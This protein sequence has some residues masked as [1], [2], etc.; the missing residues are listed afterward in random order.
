[1]TARP[2]SPV[3]K[4]LPLVF[5]FSKEPYL[6]VVSMGISRMMGE[7][8]KKEGV[9]KI[10]EKGERSKEDTLVCVCS[11]TEVE[12]SFKTFCNATWRKGVTI[13]SAVSITKI[14]LA[15]FPVYFI[16]SGGQRGEGRRDTR[17]S[18]TVRM[19]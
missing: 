13:I 7:R 15:F 1:M 19:F 12:N 11:K 14:V 3:F 2:S 16:F 4:L 6:L 9:M 5:N 8:V 17:C 10:C 18:F